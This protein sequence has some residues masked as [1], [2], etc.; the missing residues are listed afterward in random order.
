MD[1]NKWYAEHKA[2]KPA[3]APTPKQPVAAPMDKAARQK[4]IAER[5]RALQAGELDP[6]ETARKQYEAQDQE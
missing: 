5:V 2:K 4:L 3:P 6:I 1:A